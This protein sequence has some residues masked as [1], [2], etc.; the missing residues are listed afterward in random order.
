[1]EMVNFLLF[2][3]KQVAFLYKERMF[4]NSLIYPGES[5][6]K[7]ED[8]LTRVLKTPFLFAFAIALKILYFA[9]YDHYL[10]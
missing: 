1:M 7:N 3:D 10:N 5:L 2:I 6:Q 8:A 9:S 4:D